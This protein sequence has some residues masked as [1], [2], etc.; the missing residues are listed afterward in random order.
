M[1]KKVKIAQAVV[2][3]VWNKVGGLDAAR[4][5]L[6]D[7]L[8]L[9]LLQPQALQR[10]GIRP[11][12]GFLLYGPPGMGKTLLARTAAA[13]ANA[14]FVEVSGPDI[15][16]HSP[17]AAED[18]LQAA[19]ALAASDGPA[20][21]FIN[22]L[23]LL[24]PI[25]AANIVEPQR[26][27]RIVHLL[28]AELDRLVVGGIAV[29]IGATSRPNLVDPALLRPGRL[30]ELVYAAV[31]DAAGRLAML[32]VM[33]AGVTL[34]KDVDL[35]VLAARTDRFTAADCED[36][37]RRAGLCA[38]R[39]SITARKIAKADFDAALADTRASVTET[40]EKE[41]EKVV[42][43]IKAN[44]LKLEPMGFFGPG[45]LKPVR[46]SKHDAGEQS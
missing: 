24:A 1:A 31:P 16:G 34:S 8:V 30:D 40:M 5:K 42:G 35:A 37:I 25:R 2:A 6:A 11:A 39:S 45:Q 46:D 26:N 14:R 41:Y 17:G 32:R 18:A 13:A 29:M 3:D 38:L 12:R 33:T 27:E 7:A 19:F 15:L 10:L 22:E 9:P 23:E 21:L 4:D 43:E 20:V 28:I 36:L 44:A